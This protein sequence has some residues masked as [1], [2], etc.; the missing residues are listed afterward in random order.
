M[1]YK[2]I[3]K[4]IGLFISLLGICLL[5]PLACS[6]IYHENPLPFIFTILICTS[7]FA[8]FLLLKRHRKEIHKKEGFSIVTFSWI[9]AS[10]I[11]ALPFVF[12]GSIPSYIDAFFETMSGFTTTGA[13][14]LQDVE[15]LP[16]GVLLWRSFTQW[17]GG[18]GIIVLFIAVLPFL[19]VGGRQLYLSEVPGP[20]PE[21]LKPRIK[22]TA[23]L[24][25]FF[26]VG[27]SAI[28]VILLYLFGMSL[29]DAL[30]HTFTTMATGGFSTKN[31]SIG[32]FQS[33]AIQI[34]VIFFML[35]AGTNFSLY[36]RALKSSP[37][38]F[39]KDSEF[40]FYIFAVAIA[41]LLIFA[42]IFLFDPSY[43]DFSSSALD[44][45]FQAV[46]ILTTTGFSTTN[47]DLWMGFSRF[48]LLLLMFVGGCAGS[49][50]GS[51]KIIRLMVMIKHSY[52]EIYHTFRP[53][54]VKS[55]KIGKQVVPD[56]VVSSITGF[57]LIYIISFGAL[58]LLILAIESNIDFTTAF[59]SVAATLGNIGPGLGKV[60]PAENYHIFSSVG[61][62]ILSFCMLLGRLELFTVLV[63]LSPTFWRR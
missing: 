2:I 47:F 62:L 58:S 1:D 38:C 22:Q 33:P 23:R 60:G 32:H 4:S 54:V 30:C 48:F 40:R 57:I 12:S 28:E 31:S 44:A 59:T 13:S 55:L 6:I 24:L 15:V 53:H 7:G 51:I 27:L 11:G 21:G 3:L 56:P 61:K 37:K 5:V 49:T 10:A 25:W 45:S 18:M 26:Y 63:L 41:I 9:F 34:T 14:I 42:Y 43:E 36:Y 46:S 39:K 29:F 35:C 19:G 17:L 50:G 52:R 8:I 16:K 20:T